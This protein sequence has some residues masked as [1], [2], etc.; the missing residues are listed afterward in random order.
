MAKIKSY[1]KK[2]VII[3]AIQF[4]GTNNRD[5]IEFIGSANQWIMSKTNS[6]HIM[7]LEGTMEAS[8][9]D[10][11]IRGVNGEFYPCKADIFVKS[12]EEVL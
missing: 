10:Y 5:V 4:D 7:T 11:V 8:A 6:I 2:P 9:G 12:Y 1:R 3:Q